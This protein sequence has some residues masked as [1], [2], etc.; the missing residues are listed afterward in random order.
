MMVAV[1]KVIHYQ[2]MWLESLQSTIMQ[3]EEAFGRAWPIGHS[4]EP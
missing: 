2:D 4:P 1:T 3:R